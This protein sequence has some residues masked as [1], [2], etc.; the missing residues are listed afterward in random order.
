M[1]RPPPHRYFFRKVDG[2]DSTLLKWT[3]RENICKFQAGFSV[4][5]HHTTHS[6]P[7]P[8]YIHIFPSN[9]A[10]SHFMAHWGPKPLH[11]L[12]HILSPF[13]QNQ[14]YISCI[15]QNFYNLKYCINILCYRHILN[16]AL[17]CKAIIPFPVEHGFSNCATR[18]LLALQ[19]LFAGIRH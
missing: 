13:H 3:V 1:G 8:T 10:E 17:V 16:T 7:P 5:H 6:T 15:F 2:V 19:S 11:S 18:T 4:S 14:P 9:V 12:Y